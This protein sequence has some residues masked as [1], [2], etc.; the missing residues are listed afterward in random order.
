MTNER[1]RSHRYALLREE[2]AVVHDLRQDRPATLVDFSATGALL[3]L[4]DVAGFPECNSKI[5]DRLELSLP[6]DGSSFYIRARVVRRGPRFLAVEF[7][8]TRPESLAA[9]EAKIERFA[10][11]QLMGAEP[12]TRTTQA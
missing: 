10:H 9:I 4:V 2:I 5:D 6:G 8:E 12:R 1:R 7:V 11:L 3:S